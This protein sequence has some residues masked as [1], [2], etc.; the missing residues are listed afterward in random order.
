MLMTVIGS[1]VFMLTIDTSLAIVDTLAIPVF[2]LLIKLAG[3]RARPVAHALQEAYAQAFAVEQENI[4]TLPAIR[5]FT[6]EK[7]ETRATKLG[8]TMSF[9]SRLSSNGSILQWA[10]ACNGS[11]FGVCWSFFGLLETGLMPGGSPPVNWSHFCSM[12]RC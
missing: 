5:A 12:Q 2:Y 4:D 8:S 1:V 9:A 7:A 3:R 10:P 6:R 11:L